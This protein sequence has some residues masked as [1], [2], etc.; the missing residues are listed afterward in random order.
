LASG[1]I[2]PKNAQRF[3][4]FL[5]IF[6]S[7]LGFFIG[8]LAF[9]IA[10]CTSILLYFYSS[11]FKRTVLWGNF[12]V[13]TITGLSFI[14]GGVAVHKPER[15]VIP[16]C[17]A[18]LFH[19]GREILKDLEDIEG[20]QLD[21]AKTFPIQYG[22]NPTRWLITITF[23]LLIFFTFL[24]Y[25]YNIFGQIYLLTVF[26]GVDLFLLYAILSMWKD[27]TKNNYHR[28][29]EQLKIDMFVGLLA[30]LAGAYL[31]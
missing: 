2:S 3:A 14:Y 1:K 20:D 22:L 25:S 23:L 28:L 15:A 5:F 6:G 18:F 31:T 9:F 24:P 12:I 29:N 7:T 8:Y 4:I 26:V 16:A 17:F 27:P 13:S 30:I 21:N 11:Y 10:A 19:F